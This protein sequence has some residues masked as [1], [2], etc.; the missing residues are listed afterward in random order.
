MKSA[1]IISSR[2]N[3]I[4]RLHLAASGAPSLDVPVRFA[5]E[6]S[7]V[8]CGYRDKYGLGASNMKARCGNIYNSQN[9]LVG[10]I[11]YNG[12]IWDAEGKVIE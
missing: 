4:Y 6:A 1:A 2:P 10:R 3:E 7:K 12:R 5:D 8:F 9:C 11:S